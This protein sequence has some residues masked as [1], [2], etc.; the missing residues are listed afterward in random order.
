MTPKER[1][2]TP[3]P[4]YRPDAASPMK[5]PASAE[6]PPHPVHHDALGRRPKPT[7]VQTTRW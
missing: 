5:R 1:G 6:P 4:H 2:T 3:V 7:L